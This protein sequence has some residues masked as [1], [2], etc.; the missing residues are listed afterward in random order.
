MDE[1]FKSIVVGMDDVWGFSI[2]PNEASPYGVVNALKSLGYSLLISDEYDKA[3]KVAVAELN[4]DTA[5]QVQ[6]N[7][8]Y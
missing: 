8:I 7:V 3:L 2:S 5:E 6:P 4:S 1:A